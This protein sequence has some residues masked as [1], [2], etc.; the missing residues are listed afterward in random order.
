MGDVRGGRCQWRYTSERV[1]VYCDEMQSEKH[2][3]LCMREKREKKY[4]L[5]W[6]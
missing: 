6:Q 3:R 4:N 1:N 5:F 2:V